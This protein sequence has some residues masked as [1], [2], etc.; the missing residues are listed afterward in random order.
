MDLLNIKDRFATDASSLSDKY[1]RDYGDYI[2]MVAESMK[3]NFHYNWRNE[4][5]VAFG[6]YADTWQSYRPVMEA[7]IT[8]RN[9]LG[10]PLQS[11]LGL[12]AMA[13]AALPIQNLASVQPL[14]EEA[15][16]IYFRDNVAVTS[17]GLIEKGKS[18][19]QPYGNV[20][21]NIDSYVS[22]DQVA[23]QTIANTATLEYKGKLGGDVRPATVRVNVGNGK[24]KGMDDGEGHLLGV[25]IDAGKSTI[26][27]TT[28][29]Y[30]ITFNTFPS[31]VQKDDVIA[32]NYSQS[33]VGAD[34]IPT[35]KWV[36]QNKPIQV[37]YDVLQS[38]Y[39][40]IAELVLRKRFGSDLS[41]QITMDLVTQITS[42]IMFKSIR[43]LRDAAIRNE[44]HLGQS[45]TWNMIAPRGVSDY[46]YRRTFDDRVSDAVEFMYQIAGTGDMTTIITGSKGKKV[47]KTAGM[48]TI[49]N[50]VAGPHLCGMYGEV[51]VYYAPNSAL[52]SNE[53]LIVYRGKNW[54]EAPLVYAPF[55]PVTV[56]S[57]KSVHNVLT[58]AQAVYHAAGLD[59]VQDGFVIRI[60]LTEDDTNR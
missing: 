52:G 21:P 59:T 55:L 51:P 43:R 7:D 56:V 41:D 60:T 32:L 54:Y 46:D 34:E 39:S 19:I 38:Q 13:Y 2:N 1:E 33:T 30:K 5:T 11:N 49:R 16:V 24:I 40:N 10:E 44:A 25:G 20:N 29:E 42:A 48:S 35:S 31:S 9:A 23:T 17:R 8:T 3:E 58:N 18:L 36:L 57:G 37:S 47:L 22:E 53:M 14:N 4:D 27:Y 50:A 28:G 15:G 6:Q 26:D 12:I 45:L